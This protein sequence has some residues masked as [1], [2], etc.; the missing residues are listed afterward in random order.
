MT[1]C[2]I[3]VV[4]ILASELTNWS[5]GLLSSALIAFSTMVITRTIYFVRG[6][7][8]L[9]DIKRKLARTMIEARTADQLRERRERS[10]PVEVPEGYGD[11]IEN[12]DQHH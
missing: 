11:I 7:L 3:V 10:R 9:F 4:M 12:G 6:I 2:Y 5:Y 8:G 1:I